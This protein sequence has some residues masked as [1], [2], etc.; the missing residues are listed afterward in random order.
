M[1]KWNAGFRCSAVRQLLAAPSMGQRGGSSYLYNQERC[2]AGAQGAGPDD[3]DCAVR[4][5]LANDR[6]C[7]PPFL[8]GEHS[9]Q[10]V[11]RLDNGTKPTILTPDALTGLRERIKTP[12][13][14]GGLWSG[15]KIAR[16][17]AKSHGSR[18]SMI[19]ADGTL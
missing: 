13:D 3:F 2:I 10:N 16:W 4:T 1:N 17:L 19:S 18:L 11:S 15:P 5:R 14:D 12:P 8:E 7:S 6:H 9:P